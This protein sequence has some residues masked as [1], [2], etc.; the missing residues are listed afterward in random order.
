[1]VPSMIY[2]VI[3]YISNIVFRKIAHAL[4]EWGRFHT[5]SKCNKFSTRHVNWSTCCYLDQITPK[6]QV[7]LHQINILERLKVLSIS[8]NHR[9]QSAYENHLI[10]KLLAVSVCYAHVAD[11]LTND[12]EKSYDCVGDLYVLFV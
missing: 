2:A 3:I 6:R 4:N 1:M 8:E 7:I 10:V 12:P 9:L 5:L 11:G